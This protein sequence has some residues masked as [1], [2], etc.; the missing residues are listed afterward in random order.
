MAEDELAAD[1]TILNV[2]SVGAEAPWRFKV[3]IEFSPVIL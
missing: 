3:Q 2:N 1:L